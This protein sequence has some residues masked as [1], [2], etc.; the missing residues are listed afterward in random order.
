[1]DELSRRT[2]VLANVR[3]SG[4]HLFEDVNRAGGVGAVLHELA[5]LLHTDALTVT[6]RTLGEEVA[7]AETTDRDVIAALDAPRSPEGGL[8]VVRGSLA[9]SGAI[10]KLSAASPELFSHR[11]PAV[12]FEDVYDLADRIDSVDATADSVFVMRNSGPK[13]GPGMPEWGQLPVPR[14]LLERGVKDVVRISDARMSGTAFGTV[15]LHVAPESAAGGPL[16]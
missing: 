16:A 9:P 11:G 8:A 15:V 5:P 6:G 12:V 2:P 4:E 3:P 7:A 10:I 1:F 13:G 14:R